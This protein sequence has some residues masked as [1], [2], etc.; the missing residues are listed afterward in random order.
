M[1]SYFRARTDAD[2]IS[3][4]RKIE[5]PWTDKEWNREEVVAFEDAI[6]Q[7]GAELRAVRDEVATRSM[8]EVVRFYGHWKKYVNQ[9]F[10]ETCH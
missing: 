2:S 8:P 6:S 4:F 10:F 1:L 5:I 7:H 3:Q 9:D